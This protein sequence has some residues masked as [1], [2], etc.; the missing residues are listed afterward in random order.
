MFASSFGNAPDMENDTANRRHEVIETL[1]MLSSAEK[2]LEYQRTVPIA[3]VSAELFCLW[4][5]AFWAEDASLRAAFDPMEW[6]ALLRFDSVFERVSRLLPHKLPPIEEFINLPLWLR[7]SRA[8]N[9]ALA[10]LRV[11]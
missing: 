3:Q 1:E 7:L 4:D 5:E 10:T 8:A 11:S 2:Q 6:Q 9:R